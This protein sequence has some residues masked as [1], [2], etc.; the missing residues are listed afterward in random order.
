VAV[1]EQAISGP[2]RGSENKR[3]QRKRFELSLTDRRRLIDV[4]AANELLSADSLTLPL[5]PPV[6]YFDLRIH[7]TLG[8][9]KRT[10]AIAAPRSAVEIRENKIYGRS[11]NL[12]KELYRMLN[13]RDASIVFDEPLTLQR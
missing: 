8:G 10:I 9:E 1:W 4:I 5:R 11:M 13:T 12:V 2:R 7:L 3:A 6:F